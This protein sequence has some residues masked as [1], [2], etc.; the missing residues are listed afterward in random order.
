MRHSS[1]LAVA[2]ATGCSLVLALGSLAC[3]DDDGLAD[4]GGADASAADSTP[5][6]DADAADA[7][8]P[9]PD[10]GQLVYSGEYCEI[11]ADSI[12]TASTKKLEL[13]TQ[14]MRPGADIYGD[15]FD[16]G[17]GGEGC[18]G[19]FAD[20][21][22]DV[23]GQTA[24]SSTCSATASGY[25]FETN[26]LSLSSAQTAAMLAAWTEIREVSLY[27]QTTV[28]GAPLAEY[29][30]LLTRTDS[31]GTQDFDTCSYS[32]SYI[33]DDF[34]ALNDILAFFQ[35]DGGS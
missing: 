24:S 7:A 3:S 16:A 10:G 1:F 12:V 25:L 13:H 6:T 9:C 19:V 17:D 23:L 4:A 27:G 14:D 31:Q 15:V 33:Y 21:T 35:G 26:T 11:V 8:V 34:K 5:D 30:A 18:T 20:V 29:P 22:F 28:C 2:V 32:T